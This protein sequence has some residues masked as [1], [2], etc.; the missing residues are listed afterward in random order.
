MLSDKR[1][2]F[3]PENRR[4]GIPDSVPENPVGTQDEAES[5]GL[6]VAH[7][8]TCS[9]PVRGV[10]RGCELFGVC[11][12][13]YK[14]K[15]LSEGGGPRR[16]AFEIVMPGQPIRRFDSECFRAVRKITD[17]EGNKGAIRIIADEGETYEKVE[18]V[19]IK[20]YYDPENS[21]TIKVPAA[22]GEQYLPNVNRGD[23]LV[24]K[25]VV[26]FVRAAENQE[27]ATDIV[28]AQVVAK[29]QERI[30]GEAFTVALG[31]EVG[32]EP[33]DK[34]NRRGRKSEA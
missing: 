26:P 29:E 23:M 20:T 25:D 30:R 14:G 6:E 28:T 32:R 2:T 5:L 27:I 34:R 31:V 19:Y 7:Y 21:Q 4:A 11:P 15:T 13:S 8:P 18:G 1:L 33:L 17:I 22:D 16:H 24:Q 3:N 9:K 12:M 10:N